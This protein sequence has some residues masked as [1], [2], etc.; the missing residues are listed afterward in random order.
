MLPSKFYHCTATEMIMGRRSPELRKFSVAYKSDVTKNKYKGLSVVES[1]TVGEGSKYCK[2]RTISLP[3]KTILST[4]HINI[5]NDIARIVTYVNEAE[6]V[7]LSDVLFTESEFKY[8]KMVFKKTL[9]TRV[10]CLATLI[11]ALNETYIYDVPLLLEDFP[12]IAETLFIKSGI[13]MKGLL[14]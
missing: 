4:S 12:N 14:C 7:F 10:H 13:L 9:E 11:K 1:S 8:N 2:T 3:Y 6:N 5:S